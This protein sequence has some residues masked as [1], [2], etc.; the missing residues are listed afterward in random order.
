MQAH[1]N[2]FITIFIAFGA[3]LNG[4]FFVDPLSLSMRLI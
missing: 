2:D 1:T 3:V 4:F